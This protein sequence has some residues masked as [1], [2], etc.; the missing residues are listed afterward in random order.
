M[1]DRDVM[2]LVDRKP[3]MK[4][5]TRATNLVSPRTAVSKMSQPESKDDEVGT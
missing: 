1:S 4:F 3:A 5:S 2:F